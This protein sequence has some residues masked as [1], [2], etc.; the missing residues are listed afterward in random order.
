MGPFDLN[1]SKFPVLCNQGQN[2]PVHAAVTFVALALHGKKA[3]N[4]TL[5]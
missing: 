5:K 2:R 1:L 3:Q 4:F